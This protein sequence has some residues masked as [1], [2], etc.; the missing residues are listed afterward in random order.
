M[1]AGST[2]RGP[3][4]AKNL[5][6]LSD[7]RL[8]FYVVDGSQ[9]HTKYPAE[10]KIYPTIEKKPVLKTKASKKMDNPVWEEYCY[11]DFIPE[12]LTFE[13][14]YGIVSYDKLK[15][16]DEE[17]VVEEFLEF[18]PKKEKHAEK[19]TGKFRVRFYR[20]SHP[21][22]RY[23]RTANETVHYYYSS[24]VSLIRTGDLVVYS[25]RGPVHEALKLYSGQP[26]ST[27]GM[28][29]K[30]P[31]KYTHKESI[32]VLECTSNQDL[33]LDAF[34]EDKYKGINIFKFKERLHQFH[35][36][37]A[38]LVR[39]EDESA[40]KLDMENLMKWVVKVHSYR[41]VE[42]A[43]G[44]NRTVLP[45]NLTDFL[46]TWKISEKNMDTMLD[47]YSP[48]M[49][50]NALEVAKVISP[51]VFSPEAKLKVTV[52]DILKLGCFQQQKVLLFGAEDSLKHQKATIPIPSIFPDLDGLEQAD[53]EILKKFANEFQ[54]S[55]ELIFEEGKIFDEGIAVIC[56]EECKKKNQEPTT[57]I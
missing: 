39:L 17:H 21:D 8:I 33:M 46:R 15:Y 49:I 23:L 4:P 43:I 13:S 50:V 31:N 22:L 9:F 20:S 56:D 35:G 51:E 44:P 14:L 1:R 26:Y 38:W 48:L 57:Q 19:A 6:N 25:G 2:K 41:I 29:V 7:E 27:V 16:L 28:I 42:D 52:N 12:S 36:P 18:K 32:Y 37:A 53:Q 10:L 24:W 30:L 55:S 40:K 3:A 47:V 54:K 11:L 45:E 34:H 5:W